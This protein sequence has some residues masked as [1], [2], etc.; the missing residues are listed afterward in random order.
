MVN[1]YTLY[2]I[3]Y[4][5]FKCSERKKKRCQ[6]SSDSVVRYVYNLPIYIDI[7]LINRTTSSQYTF[8]G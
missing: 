8:S 7:D 4:D 6:Q 1:T 2:C 5:C 3:K